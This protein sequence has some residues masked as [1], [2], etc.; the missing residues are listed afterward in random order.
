[1][2]PKVQHLR[3]M[4]DVNPDEL[5]ELIALSHAAEKR[6][7]SGEAD[8][9]IL[10]RD[11]VRKRIGLIFE[12]PSTRTIVASE[13]AAV[14]MGGFAHVL[15]GDTFT[16]ADGS[17]REEPRD[18][19]N[20]LEALGVVA[21]AARVRQQASI[22]ALA[23]GA[24]VPVINL[25]SSKGIKGNP[26]GEHPTQAIADVATAEHYL[27][28]KKKRWTFVGDTSNNVA[29]SLTKAVVMLGDDMV[30]SGP[31]NPAYKIHADQQAII[32]K[33]A[34]ESGSEVSYE[35]D[36]TKAVRGSS[37]V[38]TDVWESMG[39]ESEREARNAEFA[40]YQ[41]SLPLMAKA[42]KG[43]IALHCLPAKKGKEITRSAL[44]A[45]EEQIFKLAGY[46]R[47]V[48]VALYETL[49]GP[50]LRG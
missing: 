8:P 15:R 10:N 4:D 20:T 5:Q 12:V 40:P 14:D 42:N 21:I 24:H 41:V 48:M 34:A 50:H 3:S 22:N 7:S 2:S 1:M 11:G 39:Q 35:H 33:L 26:N 44:N 28:R 6:M 31:D 18:V 23:R 37:V 38:Y 13:G 17:V 32:D 45:Y 47:H 49:V 25:L 16:Y 43:A 36:P 29:T 9:Q 30:L 19:R 27:G 46:R